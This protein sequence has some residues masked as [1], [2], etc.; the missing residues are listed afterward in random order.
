[1]IFVDLLV[2]RSLL[3]TL[4]IVLSGVDR[5]ELLET[6][7]SVHARHH[8]L[9]KETLV[10]FSRLLKGIFHL[11]NRR[12]AA[13]LKGSTCGKHIAQ[14]R[15]FPGLNVVLAGVLSKDQ[16]FDRVSVVVDQEYYGLELVPQDGR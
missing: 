10:A 7:R 14:R 1:M 4:A 8:G 13:T 6:R 5:S 11:A 16:P 2:C 15:V 12:H 3:P 9:D